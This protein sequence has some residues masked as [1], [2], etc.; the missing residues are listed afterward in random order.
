M[1]SI[2]TPEA[3]SLDVDI[4][5]IGS[6]AGAFAIDVAVQLGIF[7]ALGILFGV[8]GASGLISGNSGGEVFFIAILAVY[9]GYFPFLEGIWDGRTVG[10]RAMHLRVVKRDGQ[11]MRLGSNLLRNAVRLIDNIVFIGPVLILVTPRHQRLGDMAGGTIVVHEARAV[12]PAPVVLQY[13]AN[14]AAPPLDTT[15]LTNQEYGL[16][17]SFLER[18]LELDQEARSRLAARLAAMVRAK[19][20]GADG[21]GP[22]WAQGP[23]GPYLVN[24]DE[25]LLE[26]ALTSVR[27]RYQD[28]QPESEAPVMPQS[29]SEYPDL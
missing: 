24:G 9:L 29:L 21:Y 4:A 26:A 7:A 22:A 13:A 16:I 3:V 23:S 25:A 20:A 18:R 28:P 14:P 15:G 6:R 11:P 10:K 2:V 19:V 5:G 8:T 1:S 12:P 17:R 27:M